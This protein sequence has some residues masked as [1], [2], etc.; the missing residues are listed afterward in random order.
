MFLYELFPEELRSL[1]EDTFLE[2]VKDKPTERRL[3][4][5]SSKVVDFSDG[6][7]H[8]YFLLCQTQLVIN[9]HGHLSQLLI[10]PIKKI[11]NL[12]KIDK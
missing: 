8:Q 12:P 7:F 9:Q 4:F 10:I 6:N 2:N 3:S 1:F 5:S 11:Y